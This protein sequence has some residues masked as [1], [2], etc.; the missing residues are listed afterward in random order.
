MTNSPSSVAMRSDEANISSLKKKRN[1]I[2]VFLHQPNGAVRAQLRRQSGPA[3]MFE[4]R[5]GGNLDRTED[6]IYG[7]GTRKPRI[8]IV[9]LQMRR[10]RNSAASIFNWRV[11]WSLT[12]EPHRGAPLA[13]MRHTGMSGDRRTQSLRT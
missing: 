8:V 6:C 1:R 5:C 4:C 12:T 11:T 9:H 10:G 2:V 3:R 7:P 13:L